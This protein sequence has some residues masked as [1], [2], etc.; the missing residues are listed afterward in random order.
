MRTR[1][2]AGTIRRS[3]TLRTQCTDVERLLWYKLRE[4]KRLG[5]RFRRQAPF[6]SYFLDFVEHAHRL[7][8]ELD[9]GQHGER[10]HLIHDRIRDEA[11]RREGYRVL[12]F[13]NSELLENIDGVVEA[14]MRELSASPP[15][16]RT[17]SPSDLPTRGILSLVKYNI[18]PTRGR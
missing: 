1:L 7:V 2:K 3:R 9:G 6:R 18:T 4:L 5:Y 14:I 16:T 13:W 8:I 15:P 17:A 12:R 11:L 10:R